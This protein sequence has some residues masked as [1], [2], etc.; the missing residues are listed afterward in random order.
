MPLADVL[1]PSAIHLDPTATDKW[2]L[3]RL[4]VASALGGEAE[5]FGGLESVVERVEQRERQLSTGLER[6]IA[7][8]HGMLP[9]RFE[10]RAALA[11]HREGIDF[12][13]LDGQPAHFI[14][15]VLFPDDEEGRRAHV[16]LLG[17][18]IDLLTSEEPRSA[19]L[20]ASTPEEVLRGLRRV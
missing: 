20:S 2:A 11:V 6:G 10:P 1:T 5:A 16:E 14:A 17:S 4:L 3:I 7:L 9:G 12:E 13:A 18:T 8:P 19:V 15:L